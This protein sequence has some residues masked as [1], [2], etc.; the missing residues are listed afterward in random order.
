ME[1]I[2]MKYNFIFMQ[3][4]CITNQKTLLSYYIVYLIYA[5]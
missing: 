5:L 2:N 1:F 4:Y 3:R